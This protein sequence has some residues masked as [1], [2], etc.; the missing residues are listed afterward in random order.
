MAP[1][2]HYLKEGWLPGDKMEAMKIQIKVACFVIIDNVLYR[3]GYSLPYLKCANSEEADYMLRKIHE[4]IC[5]NHAGAR[6]LVGKALRTGYYWSTLQKDPHDL[7]RACNKCQHYA[8]VQT[9]LRE[10][11]TPISSPWPFAQWGI[12]IMGL[13]PLRK[14]QLRF[15]IIA[16]D[17]F[18]K[19]VEAKPVTMITEAKIISFVWKNIIC[20]FGVPH[21][22][23]PDN[24]KQFDNPKFQKIFQKLGVKNYY[25]S[26]RHL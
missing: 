11:M 10:T 23:I 14:K 24:E 22:I 3:Q 18:T 2:V 5:K 25:S 4:G 20:R 21:V 9:R 15:L 12:D 1:I 8:N 26:P 17:Y 6:S 16:I 7:V 19:W 13:F